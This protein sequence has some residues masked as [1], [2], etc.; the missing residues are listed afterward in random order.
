[1]KM[2]PA[3]RWKLPL[4]LSLSLRAKPH[5]LADHVGGQ[6]VVDEALN[7]A[8]DVLLEDVAA[9]LLEGGVDEA[10]DLAQLKVRQDGTV[11]AAKQ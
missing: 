11:G 8:G 4:S 6:G 7:D 9:R 1:M 3:D 10:E 2:E 5:L